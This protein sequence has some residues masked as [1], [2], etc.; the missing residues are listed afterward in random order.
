MFKNSRRWSDPRHD[1]LDQSFAVWQWEVEAAFTVCH[2]LTYRAKIR[3][4]MFG[5]QSKCCF[6]FVFILDSLY[7]PNLVFHSESCWYPLPFCLRI[8]F[9]SCWKVLGSLVSK[10]VILQFL[11]V[12]LNIYA[13]AHVRDYF[14][15][16]LS[17]LKMKQW[18][19]F[20]DPGL[21]SLP[22]FGLILSRCRAHDSSLSNVYNNVFFRHPGLW[23][24][25]ES[26]LWGAGENA[27]RLHYYSA[28]HWRYTIV[29]LLP[30]FRVTDVF[31]LLM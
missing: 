18:K 22:W 5:G 6:L 3:R 8:Q 27:G 12:A 20:F 1:R 23:A 4:R 14:I 7:F 19:F 29:A 13:K 24:A 28:Q 2:R 16:D 25:R 9:I 26:G 17:W 31:D 11:G 30:P 21:K 15:K 10:A